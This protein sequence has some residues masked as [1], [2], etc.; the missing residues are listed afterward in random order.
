MTRS[1]RY[2]QSIGAELL[3][4]GIFGEIMNRDCYLLLLQ[5]LHFSD[6]HAS[7]SDR[8]RK[9]HKIIDELRKSFGNLFYPYQIL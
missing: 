3:R 5:M 6:D 4:S 8:L 1:Y 9:I 7:N 2:D